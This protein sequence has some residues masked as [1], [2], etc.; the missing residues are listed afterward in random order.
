M[1][2]VRTPDQAASRARAD[3]D[4][5]LQVFVFGKKG[6]GGCRVSEVPL[7]THTTYHQ[8]RVCRLKC[9]LTYLTH[10]ASF[11]LSVSPYGY[12]GIAGRSRSHDRIPTLSK[13]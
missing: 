1:P 10:W 12:L 5:V 4:E 8:A 3:C 2:A 7:R 9:Y 11:D 6:V 13:R